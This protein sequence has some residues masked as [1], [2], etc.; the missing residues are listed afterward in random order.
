MQFLE[1]TL[2]RL[3]LALAGPNRHAL[4]VAPSERHLPQ[5][6]ILMGPLVVPAATIGLSFG[7]LASQAGLSVYAATVMSATSYA[8]SAQFAAVSLL[9]SEAG[10]LVA[11]TAATL[12]NLR[13]I[14]MGIAIA[15]WFVGPVWRRI[16]E[17]QM[18][19]DES[20]A[21]AQ[22]SDG[23]F[24]RKLMLQI[25]AAFFVV[26]VGAT[27]IGASLGPQFGDL[28]R[29]GLDVVVPVVFLALLTPRLA[30]SKQRTIAL[31]ASLLALV[32]IP[33]APPG[34]PVLVSLLAVV[35]VGRR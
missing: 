18:I 24:N 8:G 19:V 29:F 23:S 2:A 14:P 17:A 4:V 26:W 9:G 1:A 25:G 13:Y 22:Q 21:L 33:Y 3:A 10:L 34:V 31:L 5:W 16:A 35:L 7:V 32:T 27:A 28:E 6:T 11:F 12:L 20:W 15:P 30:D